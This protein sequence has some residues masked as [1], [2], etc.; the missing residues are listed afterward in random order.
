MA[1][2]SGP[3]TEA[4]PR[5]LAWSLTR[6]AQGAQLVCHG[7]VRGRDLAEFATALDQLILASDDRVYV[8]VS[9]VTDWS[10]LAQAMLLSANRRLHSRGR[11]LVL[12]GPSSAL[13]RNTYL[14]DVFGLITTIDESPALPESSPRGG[15]T[16]VTSAEGVGGA[17]PNG[18]VTSLT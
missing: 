6:N 7:E 1:V 18:H 17:G 3:P 2:I 10:L 5:G 12:V 9:A 15:G 16:E 11:H 8:D 14:I 4:S 13:R